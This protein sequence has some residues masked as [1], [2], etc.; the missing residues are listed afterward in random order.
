VDVDGVA[1]DRS[2]FVEVVA[3]Q[4]RLRGAQ[5]HKVAPDALKLITVQ[6]EHPGSRLI[7]ARTTAGAAVRVQPP[8]GGIVEGHRASTINRPLRRHTAAP[9]PAAP[10]RHGRT[11]AVGERIPHGSVPTK[12]V[13][14]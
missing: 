13:T 12:P 10:K 14:R 7:L 11:S 2:V 1:D 9:D 5:F 3:H 4:N 6:R 8:I